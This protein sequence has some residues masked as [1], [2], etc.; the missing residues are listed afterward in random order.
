MEQQEQWKE[1]TQRTNENEASNSS[2]DQA[3]SNESNEET[4][5]DEQTSVSGSIVR[6]TQNS[7]PN[8]EQSNNQGPVLQSESTRSS[9][10]DVSSTQEITESIAI[11]TTLVNQGQPAIESSQEREIYEG[12]TLQGGPVLETPVNDATTSQVSEPA[13]ATNNGRV[14]KRRR[15]GARRGVSNEVNRDDTGSQNTQRNNN[16]PR[17][18]SRRQ[19]T[20]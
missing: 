15:L 7:G 5:R 17:R 3:T 10:M 8:G 2:E 18:S 6:S 11:R 13:L 4:G 12:P 19:T 14:A 16:L 9:I 1:T 20:Q